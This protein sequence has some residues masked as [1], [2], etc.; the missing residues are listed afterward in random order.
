MQ[1]LT[2]WAIV[3]ILIFS[4]VS[5][6]TTSFANNQSVTVDAKTL[7]VRSGPGLTYAV[8]G[9][10]KRGER[11]HP[12]AK[13]GDWIQVAMGN[14]TGWIA[15]WLTSP[16]DE[17]G[18]SSTT[19]LS[20]VDSLN[21][22]SGPSVNS[23]ILGKM[24]AG[25]NA[26]MNGKDGNWA[27]ITFNSTIGWVHT[28]YINEVNE[29]TIQT[30][31]QET[32]TKADVFTVAVDA[33]NVRKAADLSSKQI[34]LIHKNEAFEIKA[35]DGNWVHILLDKG[36]EGWVYSFHG[37]ISSE[38]QV[39][40]ITSSKSN[41]ATVL[42]NGTNL[43]EAATT[44]STVVTR[45]NAGEQFSIL[46]E[47][48]DWY[49]VLLSEGKSAFVAKWVVS[50]DG[51]KKAPQTKESK[52][53]ARVPGTLNGLTIVIDPGH[54]GNDRG[55]TGVR[56]TDE[57]DITLLTSERLASK[58]KAA[59]AN[60]VFTRESDSYVSLRKRVSVSHQHEA[61][62]FVSVHYDANT[63]SSVSG[64]TTY[65]THERQQKL[66]EAINKG[67]SKSIAL[68]NRGAQPGDYLVLRENRQNAILVELGFLSNPSEER[69]M[70]TDMF[71]DQATLGIYNGLLE[72]FDTN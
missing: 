45:A 26:V 22:R 19:I 67:L 4:T 1:K 47:D 65:Y 52:K 70:T 37:K 6:T 60:V 21:I 10:L 57:K 66:A 38:Q 68:R 61:D 25:D 69:T 53:S 54:G 62:A 40:K 72:Y 27:Q 23:E 3:L 71:R 58:L 11:I 16:E 14:E 49:E 35:I 15:A 31:H 59:G 51:V 18:T 32:S 48:G 29:K 56:G 42:S 50:S 30:S 5:I 36:K 63:S 33:L 55:T 8:I 43:R 12:L 46:A 24:N 20:R 2:T 41:F 39:S 9:S 34:G 13:S 44:N 64:F 17:T 7:N 28:D